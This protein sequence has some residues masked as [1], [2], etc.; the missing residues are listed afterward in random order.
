MA[1][2]ETDIAGVQRQLECARESFAVRGFDGS[3]AGDLQKAVRL[4]EEIRERAQRQAPAPSLAPAVQDLKMQA[5][6]LA[7]LIDS[8]A[9]FYRG[10]FGT[11]PMAEGYTA[12][13]VWTAS[14]GSVQACGLSLEA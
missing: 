5:V 8:A 6:R 10:W 1:L 14:Q 4:L 11:A 9:A 2:T 3:G 12:E 7:Q 13:G